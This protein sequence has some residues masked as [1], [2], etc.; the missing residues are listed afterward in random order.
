MSTNTTTKQPKQNNNGN[1]LLR[2]IPLSQL[3]PPP[4][5][6]RRKI[7][8]AKLKELTESIKE[9]GVLQPILVREKHPANGKQA[10]YQIVAGERRYR[11]AAAA[12]LQEIP[13]Q[14]KD[15]DETAALS[16]QLIEN[17]QREDIHPL[18]EAAGFLRLQTETSLSLREMA[19]QV[20]KEARYVARRLALTN[21]IA[22]AQQDFRQ[23]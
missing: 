16:A 21:L 4:Q 19:A 8:R 11:A 17:L 7:D 15:L 3:E 5:N 1:A 23:D 22:E 14:I 10:Q 18:D 6:P 12:G 20:A 9:R 2:L 13:A